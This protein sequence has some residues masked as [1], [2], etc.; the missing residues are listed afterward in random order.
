[1]IVILSGITGVGKSYFKKHIINKLNFKNIVIVT[2]RPKRKKEIDGIDKHFVTKEQFE[3]LK[4]TNKISVPFEFL[5]NMYAYYTSD[6]INSENSITEL[7]YNTITQF[8]KVA[9]DVVS[10]Y[11]K[12]KNIEY[13]KKQLKI[14]KLPIKIE[15]KRLEEIKQQALEIEKNEE[16]KNEFDYVIYNDYTEQALQNIINLIKDLVE[17]DSLCLKEG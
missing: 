10:I 9:K 17:Q 14:R 6:I 7:H 12:P 16:L 4:N 8:K 5:G 11:I 15:K 1:M 13:A 3:Q 2:T